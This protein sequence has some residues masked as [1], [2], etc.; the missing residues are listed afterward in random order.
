MNI[1][2]EEFCKEKNVHMGLDNVYDYCTW[3]EKKLTEA[4][5]SLQLHKTQVI[6]SFPDNVE[7]WEW[8]QTQRFQKEKGEQ[9]YTM[10]YE[11]DLPKILKAFTERFSN[12]L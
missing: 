4:N 7:I 2:R 9:E 11:I 6:S 3:L 12:C 8:W 5:Q 1:L 10:I